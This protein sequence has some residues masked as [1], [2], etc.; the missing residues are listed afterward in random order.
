MLAK[1]ADPRFL[2]DMKPLLPVEAAKRIAEAATA[3][4]FRRIITTL[5]DRLPGERWGRADSRPSG[6]GCA[7]RIAAIRLPPY[8][9][10]QFP[11]QAIIRPR[12]IEPPSEAPRRRRSAHHAFQ[13]PCRPPA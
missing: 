12:C 10:E 11:S 4:S 5:V 13:Q 2:T 3:D 1:L 8:G 6:S 9:I 7:Q